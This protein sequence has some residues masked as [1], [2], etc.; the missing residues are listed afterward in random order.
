MAKKSR[1]REARQRRQKQRRRNQ[2]MLVLVLIVALAVVGSAVAIVS[3]QPV[4]AF[5][6]GELSLRYDGIERSFSR[7]GYPRLGNPD[8]PVT[9]EEYS[10][11]ACP[12]CEAFHR[13][14]LDA[15]LERVKDEQVLFTYVPLNT[16]SIPNAPG[17]S[18]AALCA[19]R[20]GMF[21]EM[22]DVLFDWQTRYGNTAF[23]QNRL[24]TGVENLGL[25]SSG[26]T[27]CFNSAEISATLDAAANAGVASTPT[28]RV[29]GVTVEASQAGSIPS[30]ATILGA[31]DAATPDDWRAGP[32]AIAP[33]QAE[34]VDAAPDDSSADES[35]DD[36]GAQTD[37][38]IEAASETESEADDAAEEAAAPPPDE[39]DAADEPAEDANEDA[40]PADE[41]EESG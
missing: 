7:E 21:W 10:S 19:G 20:Q 23:S 24:L 35:I 27:D 41:P 33:E 40:P 13:D 30:S 39:E 3:N 11:F 32:E 18:R 16:G 22:H 37:E 36:A 28:L 4:D 9:I 29:N 15:V 26:F 1:T 14:S 5:L 34:P 2:R 17:A 8:A 6:P 38:E 25:N 12:G 31:I